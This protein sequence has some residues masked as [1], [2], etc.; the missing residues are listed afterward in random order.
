MRYKY[1]TDIKCKN[2][3][4]RIFRIKKVA[5]SDKEKEQYMQHEYLCH[6][7]FGW[8]LNTFNIIC[9]KC[10]SREAIV[11]VKKWN[12]KKQTKTEK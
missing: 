7:G 4:N 3:G 2:C 11:E 8:D 9:S 12:M 10:K 1:I 5:Y 6:D